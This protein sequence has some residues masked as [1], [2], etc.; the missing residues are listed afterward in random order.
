[1][2]EK[3]HDQ[4]KNMKDEVFNIAFSAIFLSLAIVLDYVSKLIPFFEMPNGGSISLGM[5]PLVLVSIVCGGG[6]GILSGIAFGLINCFVIDAYGFNVYSFILDYIVAFSGYAIISV[7]RNKIINGNRKYF[8]LG[9]VLGGIIRLISS[10]FSGVI[11]AKLWGYD[12]V[13]LE[14]VFGAGKGSRMW[15]YIYSFIYYNLP[16]IFVTVLICILIGMVLL[17]RINKMINNR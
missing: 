11:N 14:G 1:M 17:K 4:I 5:L 8:V 7:F 3:N 13:F 6:Y 2:N 12:E 9:V 16:Y 15:L 10:G